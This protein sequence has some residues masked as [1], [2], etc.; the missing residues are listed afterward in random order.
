MHPENSKDKLWYY[1]LVYDGAGSFLLY[2][3]KT[4]STFYN[5]LKHISGIQ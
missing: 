1:N 3:N 2:Y 5:E 4:L